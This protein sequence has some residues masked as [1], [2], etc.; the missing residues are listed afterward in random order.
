MLSVRKE[1][2]AHFISREPEVSHLEQD[3]YAEEILLLP[4]VL[5]LK[6]DRKEIPM[7]TQL[8]LCCNPILF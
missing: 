2:F 4:E 7:V 6:G 5:L 1:E 3:N 8:E